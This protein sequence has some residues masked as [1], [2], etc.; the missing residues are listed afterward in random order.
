MIKTIKAFFAALSHL[1][2]RSIKDYKEIK[3]ME[4]ELLNNP[5]TKK[6][7]EFIFERPVD[8]KDI[9]KRFDKS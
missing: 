4:N 8:Y 5:I 7:M 3:R 9:K 1:V 2:K 6:D